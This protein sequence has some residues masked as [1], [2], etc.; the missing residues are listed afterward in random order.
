MARSR[1]ALLRGESRRYS[2][3]FT[4]ELVASRQLD[5]TG[6]NS[7]ETLLAWENPDPIDVV[8]VLLLGP[9][10]EQRCGAFAVERTAVGPVAQPWP[11][12]LRWD[13]ADSRRRVGDRC[14]YCTRRIGHWHIATEPRLEAVGTRHCFLSSV[15]TTR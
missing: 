5:S 6:E 11:G 7:A 2:H 9:V 14:G 15:S 3:L 1:Y 12:R 4:V 8:V 13:R 10:D